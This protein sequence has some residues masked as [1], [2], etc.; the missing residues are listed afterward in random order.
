MVLFAFSFCLFVRAGDAAITVSIFIAVCPPFAPLSE[1]ISFC[2]VCKHKSMLVSEGFACFTLNRQFLFS[3][4]DL[5]HSICVFA[6]PYLA[7]VLVAAFP[8][9][10]MLFGAQCRAVVSSS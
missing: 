4:R 1:Q 5:F 3:T 10:P 6:A 9:W 2:C 8:L 7:H